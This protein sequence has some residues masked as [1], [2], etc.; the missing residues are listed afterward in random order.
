M[1]F[2]GQRIVSFAVH[3]EFFRVISIKLRQINSVYGF[4]GNLNSLKFNILLKFLVF[5][6]NSIQWDIVG[7]CFFVQYFLLCG[8]CWSLRYFDSNV[9]HVRFLHGFE[10]WKYG[11]STL[12]S[13][14]L[15]NVQTLCQ[16]RD[17]AKW[18]LSS[19]FFIY[20]TLGGVYWGNF[21]LV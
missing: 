12:F 9:E 21:L 16:R 4:C 6:T 8:W 2:Y 10:I 11:N 13:V 3:F 19:I 1:V 14:L 15:L 18:S 7:C 5:W 17:F 20:S